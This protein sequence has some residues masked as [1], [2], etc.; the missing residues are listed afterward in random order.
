MD[1]ERKTLVERVVDATNDRV[2]RVQN[3]VNPVVSATRDR[4]T[5]VR[6]KAQQAAGALPLATREDIA[7]LQE[8]V[9]RIEATLA[10]LAK[11]SKPAARKPRTTKPKQAAT[12]EPAATHPTAD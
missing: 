4:A 3:E 12:P 11:K 1:D 7:R 6:N 5:A 9:D 2:T 8:S 10:D